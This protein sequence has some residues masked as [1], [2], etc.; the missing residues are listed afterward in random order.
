MH[1]SRLSTCLN[2]AIGQR[3]IPVYCT[4]LSYLFTYLPVFKVL[5]A[6]Y[7]VA[8]VPVFQG[9]VDWIQAENDLIVNLSIA[10]VPKTPTHSSMPSTLEVQLKG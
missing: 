4:F 2:E 10:S 1:L 5:Q 7:R 8:A 6:R 9:C 3:F